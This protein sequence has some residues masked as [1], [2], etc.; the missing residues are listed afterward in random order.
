MKKVE[1]IVFIYT[2]NKN[3]RMK[4]YSIRVQH[5]KLKSDLKLQF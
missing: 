5:H 4:K 3:T 1:N 2:N